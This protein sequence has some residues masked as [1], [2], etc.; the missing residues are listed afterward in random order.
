M[1]F[2]T[3]EIWQNLRKRET[4]DDCM[5]A[6]VSELP[7]EVKS[8]T[9]EM[10]R[11]ILDVKSAVLELRNQYQL[12]PKETIALIHPSDADLIKLWVT[13]GAKSILKKLSNATVEEGD[14]S[15]ITFISGKFQYAALLNI[16]IDKEAEIKKMQDE[17]AYYEGFVMSVDKKLSN[18]KFVANAS[19]DVVEKERQKKADGLSK[20]EQL[21]RSIEQLK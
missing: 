10:M 15:G 2:I 9:V 1:P 3:E 7:G 20:I 17:I 21:R 4:G 18:E 16:T 12:S 19:P 8:S 5:I 14:P 13:P 6:K 11:H